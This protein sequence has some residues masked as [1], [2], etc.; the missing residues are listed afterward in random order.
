MRGRAGLRVGAEIF[1]TT[2][3]HP[4]RSTRGLLQPPPVRR[5]AF[6]PSWLLV[7]Q[8]PGGSGFALGRVAHETVKST[9]EGPAPVYGVHRIVGVQLAA[10]IVR[11]VLAARTRMLARGG[12]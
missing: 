7:I 12:R 2:A 9:A 11:A 8:S 6:C 3:P 1:R 5:A 10:V 4:Q